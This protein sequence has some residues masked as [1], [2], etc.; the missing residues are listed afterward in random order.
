M[1]TAKENMLM[2]YRHEE[3][4]W[5]PSQILDQDTC[6]PSVVP[7][8]PN[9]FGV[10]MDVFGVSWTFEKGMEGPMVT[11]GTKRLTDVV[12]WRDELTIPDPSTYKWE[13]GVKRDT[14]SW[15]REK[16][17]TSI[18]IVDGLFEQLHAMT[19]IEDALCYLLTEEEETYH[20]LRAIADY[21]IE[22][23][24]LIARHYRPDKIQFHDDYGSNDR[25]FMSKETWQKMIK[26]HLKRVVDA[27]HKE[28]MLYEHHSCGYIAP[29]IEEFIDLGFDALNPLQ[30]T[31]DP[32]A[33]KRKYGKQLCF[34]G[35]FDNQGIL[36][37]EHVTYEERYREIKYRIELM[38]PGGSWIADPTMIDPGISAPLIDVL[39][40][41]NTPLWNKCGYTPPPKPA[42]RNKTVYAEAD[43]GRD[44]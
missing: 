31:N 13:E 38:A 35:G 34:V 16:K 2:A 1:I 43:A 7:E 18:I 4:C 9:G 6:L 26:P 41:I 28:G 22:E 5:V 42:S 36:D 14:P 24:K 19:G 10:T 21:R 25:M 39:Y 29:L 11:L 33:L 17:L 40:E 32:Y 27:V 23:I 30:L 37:R 12:G 20:L 15:N 3:P 8:G 44:N